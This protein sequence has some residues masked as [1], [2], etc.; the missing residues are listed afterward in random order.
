MACAHADWSTRFEIERELAET[1]FPF[2]WPELE[3]P[4]AAQ[5][6]GEHD[7]AVIVA[8]D[9]GPD[10]STTPGALRNARAW[11]RWLV[12]SRGVPPSSVALLSGPLATAAQVR[13]QMLGAVDKAERGGTL[14]F[15]YVGRAAPEGGLVAG[16]GRAA[17][18]PFEPFDAISMGVHARTVFVLDACGASDTGPSRAG[19]SGVSTPPE[20]ELPPSPTAQPR[21]ANPPPTD[22]AELSGGL[23]ERAMR[24]IPEKG[25]FTSNRDV[26]GTASL[27]VFDA[28]AP[29]Q[30]MRRLPTRQRPALSYLVLAALRGW[31]DTNR[32]GQ[33]TVAETQRFV[34][35]TYEAIPEHLRDPALS[36]VATSDA[37]ARLAIHTG[38]AGPDFIALSDAWSTSLRRLA[39]NRTRRRAKPAREGSEMIAIPG[40][41]FRRGCNEP[42]DAHC[43]DDEK[44]YDRVRV[45]GFLIDRYEATNADYAECVAA[46]VCAPV[47]IERCMVWNGEVFAPSGH[48]EPA[49]LAPDHPVVCLSWSEARA[50]CA[51][52]RKR[53]P[54]EAEWELAARGRDGRI[55]PWGDGAPSCTY[56]NM[57]GCGD[58]TEAVGSHP[59]G[60]SPYG[61]HDMAGNVWEWTDS[62]WSRDGYRGF[63]ARWAPAKIVR[64]GSFYDEP[65][66]LRTSYRYGFR[67]ED[68]TGV[69]GVRCAADARATR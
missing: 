41:V 36:R 53:L 20:P 12:E 19:K 13:A 9:A 17:I 5:G 24:G 34:E 22:L 7:A 46:G 61:L 10:G 31:A 54:S 63:D 2:P 57:D 37:H 4:P 1:E 69:V 42:R 38:E 29:G 39:R 48:L 26:V 50:Y 58:F 35:R 28:G 33:V 67:P 47:A 40:T 43:E 62:W 66:S 59:A 55:Y 49:M 60:A 27:T 56:A 3:P 51:F 25:T 11:E 16:D 15:L 8:I 18:E 21:G 64:G 32:D 44:P 52:A 23:R 14:W 68:R 45:R 30:C 6:G 65:T